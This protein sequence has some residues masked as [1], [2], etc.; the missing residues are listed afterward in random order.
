MKNK[1]RANVWA[2][3]SLVFML[4][5]SLSTGYYYHQR[6]LYRDNGM[7]LAVYTNALFDDAMKI[8]EELQRCRQSGQRSL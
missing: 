4:A 1:T 6:N 8:S 7:A 2:G 5:G 3:L